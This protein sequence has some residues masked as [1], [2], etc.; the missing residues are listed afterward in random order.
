MQIID[1]MSD[2][3]ELI[4]EV[5]AGGVS[6]F[7]ALYDRCAPTVYSLLLRTL[8][9]E[10]DADEVLQETFTQAWRQA[11]RFDPAR[12]TAIAWLIQLARSRAIDRIRARRIRSGKEEAAALENS[13]ASRNVVRTTAHDDAVLAETRHRVRK[14]LGTI[15]PDQREV[16]EL[17]YFEGLTH[18]EIA[19]RL[20]APLGTVKTRIHLAMK[21]L[22]NELDER[23]DVARTV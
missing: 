19:A 6:A 13:S 18:T 21:K 15:P 17:A 8:K 9:R 10:E 3:N 5:A 11:G 22:R 16:V 14:A 12:G 2:S 4:R 7:E 20:G 1:G 23:N